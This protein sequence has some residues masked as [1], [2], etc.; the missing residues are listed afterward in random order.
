[1]KNGD[2]ILV[3]KTKYKGETGII[4]GRSDLNMEAMYFVKRDKK[5]ARVNPMWFS[6]RFLAIQQS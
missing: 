6:A 1:M 4:V 5:N 3:I 2:N